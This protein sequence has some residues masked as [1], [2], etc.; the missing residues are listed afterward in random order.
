M[1]DQEFTEYNERKNYLTVT[2]MS[3]PWFRRRKG[4]FS[5]DL[6]WGYAP[7]SIEGYLVF[8]AWL[9]FLA[10]LIWFYKDSKEQSDFIPFC[11]TVICSIG[12]VGFISWYKCEK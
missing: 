7:I 6:G 3:K 12:V 2:S 8:F 9:L 11:F 10:G 5:K 4:L 1:L